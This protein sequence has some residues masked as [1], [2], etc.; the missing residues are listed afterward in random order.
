MRIRY[1]SK[2]LVLGFVVLVMVGCNLT[3]SKFPTGDYIDTEGYVTS[4]H[5]NGRFWV[6]SVNTDEIQTTI[7][8]YSVKGD[9][10]TFAKNALC[11]QSEGVYKWTLDGE[12]LLFELIEDDCDSRVSALSLEITRYK[13]DQ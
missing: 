8:E 10:I 4:F 6:R 11:P 7:G 5:V 12:R 2:V 1:L 9:T 13:Y 3:R